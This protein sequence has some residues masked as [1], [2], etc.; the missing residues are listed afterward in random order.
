MARGKYGRRPPKNAP[1]LQLGRYLTGTVPAHPAAADYLAALGG[2]WKM[3]GNDE[4]GDCNS[5]A[6]ANMRRLVTATL[7]TEDYPTQAQVWQFYETQN[8]GFD[9][10]GSAGTN[11]PGSNYDQGMEIQT[12]LEYLTKHG[13]PDG[14][15]PAAFAKVDHTNQAEVQAALAIFGCLWLGILVLDANQDQF[16][17]GKP[18][19]DVSGSPV[20]GG[21][22]VLA[23]GYNPGVRFITWGAETELAPSFWAGSD[24]QYGPLVEEA[25]VVIWPEQ[26]GTREFAQGIDLAALAADYTAITGRPFPAPLPPPA[27]VPPA[28][29]QTPAQVLWQTAGPWCSHTRTR[30]DLVTLKAALEAFATAEG[31]S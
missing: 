5:V 24:P 30:P 17:Q 31:L 25:W 12:G 3:L 16:S 9:P 4:A 11:G 14:V 19:T 6:W 26:M 8:P 20:D 22:A 1:A 7:A 28:P 23:G 21:H 27:P 2:G 18:W 29:A 13:G 10:D 15:K